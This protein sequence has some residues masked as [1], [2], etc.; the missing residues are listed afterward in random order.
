MKVGIL[1]RRYGYNMGS[2]LQAFAMAEMIKNLGHDVKIINYDESS[3]HPRW[4]IRPII[5]HGLYEIRFLLPKELRSYLKHRHCQEVRFRKFEKYHF[6]LTKKRIFGTKKLA[7]IAQEFDKIVVGSDQIWN[8]FLYDSNYYG[9]FLSSE[10]RSKIIP[11]APSIG[12]SEIK[13]L[14]QNEKKLIRSLDV[15][16]CREKE[17]ADILSKISKKNVPVVLDP[18]L[19]VP[20]DIWNSLADKYPLSGLDQP[21]ALTYFL[22][23]EIPNDEI[24]QQANLKS[25]KIVN[26]SMFNKP[27]S[28]KSD[29][30]CCDVGP[31]E[32]LYLVKNAKIVL[33]DSFHATIFSWIFSKDFIV[34]KR[35]KEDEKGNQNSRIYTLLN[36]IGCQS[37]LLHGNKKD[38]KSQ[39]LYYKSQSIDYLNENL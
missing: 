34:V 28:V 23:S 10:D 7:L 27:N 25:A 6:P 22:G 8:P 35:F 15:L 19:M 2:T 11:Y 17:G 38:E 4:R 29:I 20:K 9:G 31:G 3:A 12:V 32:F 14:S 21:Y 16:S 37:R 24:R 36:I 33:T 39:M 30:C 26:I 1:T 5:D 18:T 13:N